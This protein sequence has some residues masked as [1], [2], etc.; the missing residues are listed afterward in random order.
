MNDLPFEGQP[1]LPE[2]LHLGEVF[3]SVEVRQLLA[4]V[5]AQLLVGDPDSGRSFAVPRSALALPASDDAAGRDLDVFDLHDREPT[6]QPGGVLHAQ[7]GV[8][9]GDVADLVRV[10]PRSDRVPLCVVQDGNHKAL[11]E[12]IESHD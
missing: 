3:E 1:P 2:L 8:K 11:L 7:A 9:V 4:L 12:V 5:A 10:S 6:E